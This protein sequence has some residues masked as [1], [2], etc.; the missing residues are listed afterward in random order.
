M[1]SHENRNL[2][3]YFK[4]N[5]IRFKFKVENN[6]HKSVKMYSLKKVKI[7]IINNNKL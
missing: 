1:P 3:I 4:K 5:I 6:I 2:K 7:I